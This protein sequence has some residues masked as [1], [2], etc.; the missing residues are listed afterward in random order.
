LAAKQY[1]M[2]LV[3]ADRDHYRDKERIMQENATKEDYWIMEGGYGI[4]GSIGA[5]EILNVTDTSGYTHIL[6]AVGTGTMLSGLIRAASPQQQLIGISVLKNQ[7][8]ISDETTALLPDSDRSKSFSI[9]HQYHF[10][11]YAKHPPGLIHFMKE[12]WYRSQVPT[13]I[14][15]TS[16][17]LF[18]AKDLIV[19]GHFPS[20]SRVLLIHSG[21]LQ[22][23][24]S[25]QT[26]ILPF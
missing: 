1:G 6:C 5:S 4:Q 13:D 12:T 24:A 17:L 11:G 7:L 21:G 26:G 9:L 15:Y 3:F 22:G 18:A 25:L 14:V 8:S 23:N 2:Q 19:K 16:K 20:G 10:G